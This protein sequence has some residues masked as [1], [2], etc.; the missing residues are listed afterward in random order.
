MRTQP[1]EVDPEHEVMRGK[2]SA[3]IEVQGSSKL[4]LPP[5]RILLYRLQKL[6]SP[7]IL[8]GNL[9]KQAGQSSLL[10]LYR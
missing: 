3:G 6:L 8:M 7:L 1:Y 9:V 2:S 10:Q 4:T 5:V